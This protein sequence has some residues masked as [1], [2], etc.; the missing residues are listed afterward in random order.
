MTPA[1]LAAGARAASSSPVVPNVTR[2]LI[3]GPG[4]GASIL[5]ETFELTPA[6]LADALYRDE[7]VA[8]RIV[9]GTDAIGVVAALEEFT[10]S[11]GA[12]GS[13]VFVDTAAAR[14]FV[15]RLDAGGPGD[16]AIVGSITRS[17]DGSATLEVD[18]LLLRDAPSSLSRVLPAKRGSR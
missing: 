2:M 12:Y 14:E 17:D 13:V 18:H 4:F 3:I 8:V 10:C 1:D 11:P 16:L 9:S 15:A 7:F 5:G 6:L